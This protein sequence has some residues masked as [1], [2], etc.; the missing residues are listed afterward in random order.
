M[1]S[2]PASTDSRAGMALGIAFRGVALALEAL[3]GTFVAVAAVIIALLPTCIGI[4][5]PSGGGDGGLVCSP[6]IS[7]ATWALFLVAAIALVVVGIAVRG[8]AS[9]STRSE[10]RLLGGQIP[11][12]AGIG[13]VLVFYRFNPTRPPVWAA[14]ALALCVAIIVLTSPR[15]GSVAASRG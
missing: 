5:A 12:L 2:P 15:S 1:P 13:F 11:V 8:F 14:F 6:V 10:L 4:A 7:L 9:R 3:T